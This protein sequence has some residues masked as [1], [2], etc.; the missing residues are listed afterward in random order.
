MITRP[1]ELVELSERV[2]RGIFAAGLY[3][4]ALTAL[5]SVG[6]VFVQVTALHRDVAAVICLA[7]TIVLLRAARHPAEVYRAFRRRSAIW[8]PALGVILAVAHVAIGPASQVLFPPTLTL[9]GVLGAAA[10][11]RWILIAALL[12]AAGQASPVFTHAL[13]TNDQ[14]A[15]ITAAVADVFIPLLFAVLI[16]YLARYMLELQRTI[17]IHTSDP[18]ILP[19]RGK[20]TSRNPPATRPRTAPGARDQAAAPPVSAR[21]IN[22]TPR[23]L[24]AI[25]LAA[26]GLRHAEIAEC[27]GITAGQVTRLLA[28]A[29]KRLDLTTNQQLVAWAIQ[30][31]IL[32]L[33]G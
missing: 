8:C 33:P 6:L 32:A 29:R 12:A 5:Y 3:V 22:V 27:L 25:A 23:Q 21:A 7:L 31:E 15:L 2:Y 24:Q 1:A 16:G 28:Q 18:P 14:R 17:T 11:R 13:S 30:A 4:A 10:P 20:V 19:P 9:I 26:E